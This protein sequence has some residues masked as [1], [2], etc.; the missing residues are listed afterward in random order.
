MKTIKDIKQVKNMKFIK[1]DYFKKVVV[2]FKN[3]WNDIADK[4]IANG[5]KSINKI[6]KYVIVYDK[7]I[8]SYCAYGWYDTNGNNIINKNNDNH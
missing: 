7:K 8:S 5:C 3:K 4:D 1:A 2:A 6:V